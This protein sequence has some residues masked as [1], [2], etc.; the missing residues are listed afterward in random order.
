LKEKMELFGQFVGDWEVYEGRYVRPDGT[1]AEERGEVHWRWILGGRAVQDVWMFYD[2]G[3]H[4]MVPAGTTVRFY[5]RKIDAWHSLWISPLQGFYRTF[6]GRQVG[7]EIVL[8]GKGVEGHPLKWI[9]SEIGHDSFRWRS[10]ASQ[11]GGGTWKL[12]EEMRIR[13]RD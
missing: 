13:R 6:V 7:S 9:F 8:E 4:K 1:W 2:E 3:E 12:D 11:D 5:E 10:E